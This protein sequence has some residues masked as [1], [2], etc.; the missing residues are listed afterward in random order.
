MELSSSA[1]LQLCAEH[2]TPS[3]FE[4]NV[5]DLKTNIFMQRDMKIRFANEPKLIVP[6]HTIFCLL[7]LPLVMFS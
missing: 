2:N 7:P 3:L 4:A 5:I 6:M 1:L